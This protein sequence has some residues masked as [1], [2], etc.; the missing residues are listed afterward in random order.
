MTH[1]THTITPK[2]TINNADDVK[3]F[4]AK[5]II[6]CS[7]AVAATSAEREG[8]GMNWWFILAAVIG[9]LLIVAIVVLLICYKRRKARRN[10]GLLL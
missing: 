10:E 7:L 8:S 6:A 3:L 1:I 4:H 5:I 9:V 2:P